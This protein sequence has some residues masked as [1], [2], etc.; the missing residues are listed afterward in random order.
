[1]SIGAVVLAAGQGI[2]MRSSLPKVVHPLA[3]RPMVGWVLEALAGAGV[4]RTV[5]VVGHGADTVRA[6]LPGEVGVAV[7]ERRLGTG[8]ATRAGLAALDPACDAVLVACGDTPL[9]PAGL[10]ARLIDDHASGGRAATILTAVLPDAGAY[11]RVVRGA[12]GMVERVVEAS[13]ATPEELAI[14]EYN[15]GLYIFSRAAL[16]SALG[17][18]APHNAQGE[19]YLTDALALL[20]G[21]VAAV[22]AEDPELAAGVND[23]VDLAACEAALQRRLREELMR[24]GVT[25]PDPSAVYVEAGVAVGAD[26]VLHPGTHLRGATTVGEGCVLGPDVV[27]TDSA[28]GD[29]CTVL[30]AH[31]VEARVA[32]EAQVGP[33]AYLRPGTRM[34]PGS[35]VGTYVETKNTVLGERA[36]VPHLSYIGDAVVGE[37]TNIGAGNITANYDGFR[38]HPTRIGARVRTGSDCV[39]VAPVTVGDDAMTGAGSIITDDV[40]EGS[41]GIA[42]A[43]QSIIEGFTAKAEAR[44]REAATDAGEDRS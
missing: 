37:R 36:K 40:P 34:E 6:A 26:T 13:D 19:L 17:R 23:R 29:R 11:G 33:F 38:K 39:F 7:Q 27:V 4:E 24:G 3:G 1:M 10:V 41:L 20:G 35:K 2:R 18:I 28:I 8:D 16:E 30:S 31:L 44:A 22:T 25:M 43:R 9:L 15:A 21:P 12:D 5:V 32:D 14:G 42:R